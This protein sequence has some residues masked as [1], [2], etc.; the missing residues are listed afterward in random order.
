MDYCVIIL[1]IF[2]LLYVQ[3]YLGPCPSG[4]ECK[5]SSLKC[6]NV[7]KETIFSRSTIITH[8][9]FRDSVVDI[10]KLT[11]YYQNLQKVD[12]VNSIA[13]NCPTSSH[14]TITGGCGKVSIIEMDDINE[15]ME[16]STLLNTANLV[17]IVLLVLVG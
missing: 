17:L 11:Q 10:L 6:E 14:I 7:D 15:L 4:C 3:D 16:D 2:I 1:F 5:L 9:E 8:A 13:E 12:L